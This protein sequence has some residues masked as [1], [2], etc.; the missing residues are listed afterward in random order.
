MS[1]FARTAILPADAASA[2]LIGRLWHTQDAVPGVSPVRVCADGVYDLSRVAPTCAQLM[3]L[4]NAADRIRD[5]NTA[6]RLG[7][8]EELI[9]STLEGGDTR[10]LSPID[11]QAIKACGVTFVKSMLERVIEERAG[12]NADEADAIRRQIADNIGQDIADVVP[13]SKEAARLKDVLQENGLWSQ[14]LEVGIG[15]DAEVFTK[16]QVL[17]SVGLG[18]QIG[19]HPNSTWNNPEPETVL[20]V[21]AVGTVVGATLGNDVNLRDVEGRSALLLGMAK[22]NNASASIGPFIRLFD[23]SFS[24]DHVRGEDVSLR[25]TG[26]DGFELN[27]VSSMSEISRDPVDLVS[28]A[29]N[30]NH[31]YPDGLALF[32]GTMFAPTQDRGEAGSGFTHVLGDRVEI[33][34]AHLGRLV[35]DVT[36]SDKAP[37]WEF[38]ISALFKNL[39]ARGL[40]N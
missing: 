25:V 38:G 18:A 27:D 9:R 30:A 10:F 35:N 31:Q 12:G 8:T 21:N 13:G 11:L 33:A 26:P 14:Y 34:S 23:E 15:P 22:D 17:S 4:S 24:M 37:P 36:H 5:Y 28:Q 40:L 7:D 32:L 16:S 2:L 20:I 6:R 3:N 39:H 29:I 19:L 1:D